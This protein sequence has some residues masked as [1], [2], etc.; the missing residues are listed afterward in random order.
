MTK[1]KL[2][3]DNGALLVTTPYDAG[4]VNELKSSIPYTDR[5]WKGDVKAWVVTPSHGATLQNLCMKYFNE[6]PLLPTIANTKPTIK[7]LIIDV[8]YIG[9]TKSRGT[10]ERSA[11]GWYHDGWNVVFP[12]SVLRAWFDAPMQPNEAQTLYSVL[13]VTRSATIDEI[14]SGHRR[15]A[16]QYHPDYCKEPDA[17]EQFLRVQHAY[18]VLNNPDK[19]ERYDAGLALEMSLKNNNRADNQYSVS[20]G[21]YRSPLRCGLIMVEGIESMGVFQVS[22]IFA[23]EDIRDSQ[24]RVLVVSWKSGDDH[25]EEVWC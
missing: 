7:Q 22:K 16:K 25:F 14:K 21:G 23:W 18:E 12:E 4:F 2:S 5:R 6:L 1:C 20:N 15:M 9:V 8:R 24:G 11:Y 13:F 10:D 17:N 3:Q 19:R